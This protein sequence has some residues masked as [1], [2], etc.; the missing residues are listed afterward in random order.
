MQVSLSK[1]HPVLL[2]F[3][4]RVFENLNGVPSEIV[5]NSMKTV[6]DIP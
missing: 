3:L 5:F 1:S 4:T 6:M 2:D